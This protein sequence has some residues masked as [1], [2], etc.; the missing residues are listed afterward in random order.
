MGKGRT[1]GLLWV[2]RDQT[3]LVNFKEARVVQN[4]I[5]TLKAPWNWEEGLGRKWGS[6]ERLPYSIRGKGLEGGIGTEK[7]VSKKK[8]GINFLQVR[9]TLW[10]D[11]FTGKF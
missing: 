1:L 4:W 7:R 9:L 5:I 6:L 3:F 8:G 2:S 10:F 11:F